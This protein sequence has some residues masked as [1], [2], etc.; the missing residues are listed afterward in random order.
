MYIKVRTIYKS[1]RET[2]ER[3]DDYRARAKPA[4][5]PKNLSIL[6]RYEFAKNFAKIQLVENYKNFLKIIFCFWLTK[7][8]SSDIFA[9]Y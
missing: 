9:D 8:L 3:V 4:Q 5:I 1:T 2:G 6:L 7:F